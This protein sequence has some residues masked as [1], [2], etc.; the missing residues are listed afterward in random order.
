MDDSESLVKIKVGDKFLY[1]IWIIRSDIK[2]LKAVP[3]TL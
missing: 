3:N 2:E 1:A